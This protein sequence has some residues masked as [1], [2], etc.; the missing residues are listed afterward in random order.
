MKFKG[1]LLTIFTLELVSCASSNASK[2]IIDDDT[3]VIKDEDKTSESS[4]ALVIYFSATSNTE[5][6]ANY[7]STHINSPIYK[8]EPVNAYTSADLNYNNSESRVVKEHNMDDPNVELKETSFSEFNKSKY[9]FLGAPVWWGKLSWVIDNFVKSNDFSN[10]T[11]IP[12]GTSAS[13]S[14]S[15]SDLKECTSD[16]TT[17]LSEKR[18]SSSAN[19]ETVTSWVDSLGI[20]F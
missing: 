10:K 1:L 17:W 5:R 7:I 11:I 16:S 13:S 19:E 9:I 15:V 14:F 12:F 6:V 4:G 20:D 2:V 8:L 18:F 3:E